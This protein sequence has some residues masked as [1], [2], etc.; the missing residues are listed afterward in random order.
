MLEQRGDDRPLAELDAN[1]DGCAPESGPEL[2]GP[3]AEGRRG[4]G[5][6]GALA[7]GRAGSAKADV[8]LLVG[9]V[10]ADERGERNGFLHG[11]SSGTMRGRDMQSRTQRSQYGEPVA[12]LSLSIR[13]GQ[14]HTRRREAEL[15]S[16]ACS[17][18][19]IRRRWVHVSQPFSPEGEVMESGTVYPYRTLQLTRPSLAALLRVHAA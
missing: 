3:I 7:L 9:P 12:R 1:G 19:H 15:V 4:V 8:V 6:D 16:I 14:R 13:Y 17:T 10:D 5:D 2:V 18:L 11:E